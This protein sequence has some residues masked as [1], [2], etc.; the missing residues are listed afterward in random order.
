MAKDTAIIAIER[1]FQGHFK[2]IL[3]FSTGD[4]VTAS[5][6]LLAIAKFLYY[7]Y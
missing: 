5:R 4:N 1:E 7:M 3:F 6:G 2:V